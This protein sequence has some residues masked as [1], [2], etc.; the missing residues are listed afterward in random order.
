MASSLLE[1]LRNVP[2]VVSELTDQTGPAWH[3]IKDKALD[4]VYEEDHS[5][6]YQEAF[7]IAQSGD[8]DVP[9]L[10]ER[11]IDSG[12]ALDALV[13]CAEYAAEQK[14]VEDT[15]AEIDKLESVLDDLAGDGWV[16]HHIDIDSCALGWLP[17]AWERD[18]YDGVLYHWKD[19]EGSG[20]ATVL[21]LQLEGG[22]I[23]LRLTKCEDESDDD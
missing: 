21:R 2:R 10:E 12:S 20:P 6:T 16:P 9:D 1:I 23:W 18:E 19:V 4:Y 7:D 13:K 22:V 14:A 3:I 8:Y 15:E 5:L 11:G 17:H